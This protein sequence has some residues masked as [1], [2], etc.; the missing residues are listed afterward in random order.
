MSTAIAAGYVVNESRQSSTVVS[1]IEGS[2]KEDSHVEEDED[3]LPTEEERKTLRLVSDKMPL[4]S[5]LI[6]VV[7]FAER[8]SYY[9]TSRPFNNFIQ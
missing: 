6:G 7:E 8:A 1:S 2:I 4:A 5:I 3:R 9:G